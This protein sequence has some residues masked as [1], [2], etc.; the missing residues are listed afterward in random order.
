M[1]PAGKRVAWWSALAVV[2]ASAGASAALLA[3]SKG[4]RAEEPRP[5]LASTHDAPPLVVATPRAALDEAR[6]VALEDRL[7]RVEARR[8]DSEASSAPEPEPPPPS[9]EEMRIGAQKADDVLH[10]KYREEHADPKWATAAA[11]SI[12]DTL[13]EIAKRG[14]F[15]VDGVDCKTTM[16]MAKFTWPS[17]Q[18]ARREFP[19]VLALKKVRCATEINVPPPAKEDGPYEATLM[20]DCEAWR[21]G[22]L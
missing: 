9:P 1:T 8:L 5:A 7:K 15:A 18:A 10:S 20:L 2:A 14:T 13:N 12:R 17:Y 3:E 19:R 11:A 4:G 22:T 6:M 16:C 21:T